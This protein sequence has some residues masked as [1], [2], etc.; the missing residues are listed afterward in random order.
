MTG[1]L[2]KRFLIMASVFCAMIVLLAGGSA[3]ASATPIQITDNPVNEG[4][5]DVHGN[6]IVWKRLSATSGWDIYLYDMLHPGER[7][8]TNA[9]GSQINP[10]TNGIF[11][12]WEDWRSGDSDI[13]IKDTLLDTETR[14]LVTGPGNQA[15]L[16]VSGNT[17]VYV[18]NTNPLPCLPSNPLYPNCP[19]TGKD[20]AN[21][22]IYAV[23]LNDLNNPFPVCT[24]AGSQ[25]Q[26]RIS[27][28]K[29]VWQDN[30]NG[31][32]DIYEK[33]LG[34]VETAHPLT[35]NTAEDSVPDISGNLVAWKS[36]RGGKWD[37]Y[38]MN[39]LDDI[40]NSVTNDSAYQNS[41]RISGDLVVWEDYRNDSNP[42][43]TYYDYDIYMKDLTSGVENLLAGGLPIQARPALDN[44]TVVWEDTTGGSYDIWMAE[45]PDTTAPF[46]SSIHPADSTATGCSSPAISA[47]YADNRAGIDT[48]T[49]VLTVDGQNVTSEA[50][51]TENSISY[52]P[53]AMQDGLH[54]MSLTV[55]DMSG[56]SA[57]A[58]WQF[59]TSHPAL[60]LWS[61]RSYW[62]TYADYLKRELSVQYR[63]SNSSQDAAAVNLQILDSMSTAGVL[64][65]SPTPL[66]MGELAP[67]AQ[68]DMVIR[69]LVPTNVGF[70]KTTLFASSL[71]TCG[72]TYYFPGPPPGW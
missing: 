36:N 32:W 19:G 66:D 24:D 41:P 5:P 7:L 49:V 63:I 22:D 10:V 45:V 14:P 38:W 40:E 9:S 13:Y 64:M 26:P 20:D 31:N 25:W 1:R 44:E 61:Q 60:N 68:G 23:N 42:A 35:T 70:F 2:L 27:G 47:G 21:N 28:N 72:G 52:Q 62:A 55:D 37:I 57:S 11:I 8:M 71:D 33:D 34:S 54:T 29:V 67:G 18:N 56:N 51:V 17:L 4:R 3:F 6:L 58:S 43:D 30:R 69:Y 39:L 65:A 46:I 53:A 50:T 48:G 15:L 59:E 16:S 12:F